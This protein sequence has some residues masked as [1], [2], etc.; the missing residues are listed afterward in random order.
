MPEIPSYQE[1]RKI[2]LP[3]VDHIPKGIGEGGPEEAMRQAGAAMASIGDQWGKAIQDA[4]DVTDV[5]KVQADASVRLN[6]LRDEYLSSEDFNKDP[7]AAMA[8][9]QKKAAA[10]RDE[11]LRN[12]PST[13]M[14][15]QAVA[16]AHVDAL[17][18]RYSNQM[19]SDMRFK[20][21]DLVRKSLLEDVGRFRDAIASAPNDAIAL[22]NVISLEQ[23]TAGAAASGAISQEDAYK[24][25]EQ[26]CRG[27]LLGLARNGFDA[28]PAGVIGR[29]SNPDSIFK[30][31]P[32]ADRSKA[33]EHIENRSTALLREARN[34]A[35]YREQER[36]RASN[37]NAFKKL[38]DQHNLGS[39][40]G[41]F[42][43]AR[44]DALDPDK[45]A[46]MDL[47]DVRQQRQ[48]ARTISDVETWTRR[49]AK[50]QQAV[51]DEAFTRKVLQDEIPPSEIQAYRDKKTNQ[52]PSTDA[53]EHAMRW[54]GTEETIRDRTDPKL[55]RELRTQTLNGDIT[56]RRAYLPYLGNGLGRSAEQE[57]EN[58]CTARNDPLKSRWLS[59]AVKSYDRFLKGVDL[60]PDQAEE[61]RNAFIMG[62]TQEM[63]PEGKDAVPLKGPAILSRATEIMQ[64]QKKLI[65]AGMDLTTGRAPAPSPLPQT[66]ILQ[67]VPQPGAA[68][69]QQG[70]QPETPVALDKQT[71]APVYK[72]PDGSMAADTS[73][74]PVLVGSVRKTGEPAY[75]LPSG[76]L[77]TGAGST[78]A[79][80]K[81]EDDIDFPESS[82]ASMEELE[83]GADEILEP[84]DGSEEGEKE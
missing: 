5:A 46:G 58:L 17:M 70:P 26:G 52:A 41:N 60:D 28:N 63:Q 48:L 40:N 69:Q 80:S 12:L 33:I 73:Q 10:I 68:S 11:L 76:V 15:A 62:L 25:N 35:K 24:L 23:A 37:T 54:Q 59:L 31:L 43:Q 66:R 81:N 84:E 20:K 14:K 36:V 77:I 16:G 49:Q 29:L 67:K 3:P 21:N 7:Q 56:D 8:T 30:Y 44:A 72:R 74:V 27:G 18:G 47:T 9:Y 38:F 53:L 32:E 82:A 64:V 57:L 78:Q 6:S 55:Y 79:A 2:D 50:E 83:E 42:A 51:V 71:K 45:A 4:Q 61:Y 75:M 22:Q 19:V 1:K 34:Q 39:P 65:D 13:S